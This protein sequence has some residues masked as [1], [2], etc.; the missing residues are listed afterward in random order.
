MDYLSWLNN[1]AC[2]DQILVSHGGISLNFLINILE[3]TFYIYYMIHFELMKYKGWVKFYVPF[4]KWMSI[5]LYHI[6][7]TRIMKL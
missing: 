4:G 3:F 6:P 7:F 1:L 5:L 2:L